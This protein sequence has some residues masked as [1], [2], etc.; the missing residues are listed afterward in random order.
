MASSKGINPKCIDHFFIHFGRPL[1]FLCFLLIFD[2]DDLE[3]L[4]VEFEPLVSPLLELELTDFF[5]A[6]EVVLMFRP[7]SKRSPKCPLS[8]N[9][10][11]NVVINSS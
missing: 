2:D 8:A 5:F 3:L 11:R 1:D 10:A 4:L 7:Y 9:M 6:V